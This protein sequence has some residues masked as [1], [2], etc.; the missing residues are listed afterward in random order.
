M[1]KVGV[2]I[3][4]PLPAGMAFPDIAR[5]A[6]LAETAGLDGIWAEDGLARGDAVVFDLMC[7]LAACAAA[8]TTIEVGS[9]I[10]APSLRN[11]SW[12]LKQVAT[13]QL[14]AQGRLQLGVALGA[15][16]EEEY[17]L[18]GL[19]RTGQRERTDEFLDALAAAASGEI[20]NAPVSADP[21]EPLLGTVLPVP[22]LWIGGT[23]VAALRRSAHFGQ[24]W[25]SGF[26]TPAEFA[27]SSR[28]LRQL[29]EE[30]GRPCPLTG[31]VLHVAVGPGPARQRV[32]QSAE[33]MQSL[34]GL[35]AE[36][37]QE[38]AIGGSPLQVAE[39]LT[40]YLDAG[41]VQFCLL[42][43]VL[44]WDESWPMLADVRRSLL[45]G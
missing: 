9:A 6:R 20:G 25:L 14:L 17:R 10:F 34:Y 40:P 32:A 44:P 43:N 4:N 29:A 18:A 33:A 3:P 15:A 31:I 27:A 26:Q 5:L 12:A 42:S 2:S 24:G 30:E 11:V 8:T 19:T 36:R 38:L 28:R 41:A 35:P 13:V 23:S 1:I 7:V 37:A 16:D 21:R 45:Q 39:Q 22:P